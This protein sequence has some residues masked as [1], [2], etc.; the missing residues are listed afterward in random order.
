M[1]TIKSDPNRAITRK[2]AGT[3]HRSSGIDFEELL[4]EA[5]LAYAQ[6]VHAAE[7]GVYDPGKSAWGTYVWMRVE[8]RLRSVI[9]QRKYRVIGTEEPSSCIPDTQPPT[10][11]STILS[12]LLSKLPEEALFAIRLVIESPT[13]YLSQ[14]RA[15]ARRDIKK[16]L[17]HRGVSAT[18]T[19]LVFRSVRKALA[20]M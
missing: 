15:S 10:D 11:R 2:L 4:G 16:T 7:T 12:N 1:K 18:R 20:G 3:Y 6:A 8:C 13:E 9:K 19:E 14:S 5:N 17:R